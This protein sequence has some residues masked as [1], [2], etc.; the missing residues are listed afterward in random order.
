MYYEVE[1][2]CTKTICVKA[3]SDQEAEDKAHDEFMRDWHEVEV[4]A[5]EFQ[6]DEKKTAKYVKE[7]KESGDYLE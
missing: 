2:T 5:T 1:I 7:Y 4:V 6:P 3:D